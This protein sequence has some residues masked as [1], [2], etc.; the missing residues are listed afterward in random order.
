MTKYRKQFGAAGERLAE[1]Y[2][3]KRGYE[4]TGRNIRTPFGEIDLLARHKAGLVF[5][6]VKTR[7]SQSLG[8]P[9]TGITATKKKH[10][11]NAIGSYLQANPCTDDWRIDVISIMKKPGKTEPEIVHFEN[12][13]TDY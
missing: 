13:I 3:V 6:E 10:L 1:E 9:E 12:A 7:S 5:I 8:M 2:L 11:L 4:I